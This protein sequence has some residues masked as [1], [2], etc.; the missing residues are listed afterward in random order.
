MKQ[1]DMSNGYSEWFIFLNLYNVY[2]YGK[3]RKS[4]IIISK[5]K[6]LNKSNHQGHK[7]I[8]WTYVIWPLQTRPLRQTQANQNGD[9]NHKTQSANAWVKNA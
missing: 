2:S 9:W 4:I 6:N 3:Y 1:G 5:M 8:Q 7:Q